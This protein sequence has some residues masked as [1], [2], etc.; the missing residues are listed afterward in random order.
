MIKQLLTALSY[1]I[2]P[3]L[4]LHCTAVRAKEEK[5]F[6]GLCLRLMELIPA[7]ERCPLCFSARFQPQERLCLACR[8]S[9]LL[10][11][12]LAAAFDY[13]GPPATLIRALK[14]SNQPYL[15]KAAASY[16][17]LQYLLL[18]WPLPDYL[19]PVPLS[20]LKRFER[21]YNQ[22]LLICLE[23]AKIL[24]VEVADV[25]K[26]NHRGY[27]QAALSRQQRLDFE[28]HQIY[29]H[30]KISLENKTVLL[31]DDVMTTGT[32]LN[33]CAEALFK[34]GLKNQYA[35]VFCRAFR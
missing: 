1:L 15:A 26:R 14:Y 35:L 13:A 29:F 24:K 2:Y 20:F 27:S 8:Q 28:G 7:A 22:S 9:P 23:M 21:G 4:C 19:V 25:L 12:R 17:A 16:M 10:F 33:K 31:V 3:P 34:Q 30:S 6:C 5:I 32:T 18:E 11:D